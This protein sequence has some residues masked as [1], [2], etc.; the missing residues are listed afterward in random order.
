MG[1]RT[2]VAQCLITRIER[3]RSGIEGYSKPPTNSLCIASCLDGKLRRSRWNEELA[4]TSSGVPLSSSVRSDATGQ[5]VPDRCRAIRWGDQWSPGR[6][7]GRSTARASDAGRWVLGVTGV[8]GPSGAPS[9][10]WGG[11]T[12]IEPRW[13][14]YDGTTGIEPRWPA[15]DGTTGIEPRWSAWGGQGERLG[16][17]WTEGRASSSGAGRC[18]PVFHRDVTPVRAEATCSG[19]ISVFVAVADVWPP[20]HTQSCGT[21]SW[22]RPAGPRFVSGGSVGA[23]RG[24][25]LAPSS[26]RHRH[27]GGS[28]IPGAGVVWADRSCWVTRSIDLS[29]D[30]AA[31]VVLQDTGTNAGSGARQHPP[32]G[33]VVVPGRG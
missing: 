6:A 3:P 21:T 17:G 22:R 18:G 31:V 20:R 16:G 4:R 1:S 23:T 11:T 12:G 10:T 30:R 25:V 9:W 2:R 8:T 29:G 5:L 19:R 33:L 15:Y 13:P 26:G 7:T 27:V 14:A 28:T 32:T 24:T